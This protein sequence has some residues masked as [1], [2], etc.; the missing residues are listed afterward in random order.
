MDRHDMDLRSVKRACVM[1]ARPDGK[2]YPFDTYNL[3]YRQKYLP[4]DERIHNAK[5]YILG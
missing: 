5:K 3:F 2:M 1:F 4:L